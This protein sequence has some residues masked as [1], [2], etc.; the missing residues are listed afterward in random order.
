MRIPTVSRPRPRPSARRPYGSGT[1]LWPQLVVKVPPD[2]LA[3]FNALA[4]A[5]EGKR[6]SHLAADLITDWVKA[7]DVTEGPSQ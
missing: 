3:R 6:G 2:V 7:R 1:A 4:L 5:L